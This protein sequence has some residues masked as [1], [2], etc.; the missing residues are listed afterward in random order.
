MMIRASILIY[1]W[2]ESSF[3]SDPMEFEKQ[4]KNDFWTEFKR[5]KKVLYIF[6]MNA[7]RNAEQ[8]IQHW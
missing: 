4:V 6:S 7:H 8:M 1:T 2:N 5:T 3:D